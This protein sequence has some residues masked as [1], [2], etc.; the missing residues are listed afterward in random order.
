MVAHVTHN[1]QLGTDPQNGPRKYD[2]TVSFI[3]IVLPGEHVKSETA[4]GTEIYLRLVIESK[5]WRM[6]VIILTRLVLSFLHN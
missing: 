5:I 2:A 3:A 6:M 1:F 4:E